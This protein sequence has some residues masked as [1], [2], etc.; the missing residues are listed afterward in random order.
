MG[1]RRGGAAPLGL[2]LLA[3]ALL[4]RVCDGDGQR[5]NASLFAVHWTHVPK[6]GG[7]AALAK[8]ALRKVKT[9]AGGKSLCDHYPYTNASSNPCYFV[10]SFSARG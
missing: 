6:A 8:Q 5:C 3:V 1:W 10:P 9:L 7:T 4:G 2:R